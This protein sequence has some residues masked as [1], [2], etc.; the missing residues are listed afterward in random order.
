V[1]AGRESG[2]SFLSLRARPAYH[3]LLD[4]NDG[5]VD[6]AQ[7]NFLDLTLR[8]FDDDHS[9]VVDDA[10]IVDILSLAP[11]DR[12]FHPVSWMVRT[13]WARVPTPEDA[14]TDKLT[15]QLQAGAGL[16]GKSG[17][18]NLAWLLGKAA[19]DAG[20]DIGKGYAAGAGVEGGFLTA[21]GAAWRIGLT[22]EYLR[23]GV[24][25]TYTRR[26][27]ALE[28]RYY[29]SARQMIGFS[30]K[31]EQAGSESRGSGTLSWSYFF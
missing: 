13:G 5:Y 11:R 10:T 2:R 25:E 19:L 15:F 4:R 18:G 27:A 8:Y 17:R 1:G 29:L 3:E 22:V 20:S 23:F 28:P 12:F 14:D 24:G 6:G 30:L 26:S 16:T 31:G 9:L 7:I 21:P